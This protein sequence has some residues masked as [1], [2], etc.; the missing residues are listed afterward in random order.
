MKN[1]VLLH[2]NRDCIFSRSCRISH[3]HS[4]KIYRMLLHACKFLIHEGQFII[5]I[6]STLFPSSTQFLS[7]RH[8]CVGIDSASLLRNNNRSSIW[9]TIP[10]LPGSSWCCSDWAWVLSTRWRVTSLVSDV[11]F[12]ER[13]R[14][15]RA[16][17]STAP[18]VTL[19]WNL[20]TTIVI[21]QRLCVVHKSFVPLSTIHVTFE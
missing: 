1:G 17:S 8:E 3:C 14:T 4:R 10:F 11:N 13:R 20:R 12:E 5:M 18:L 2:K 19:P 21:T 6:G 7:R 9:L 16:N 15:A